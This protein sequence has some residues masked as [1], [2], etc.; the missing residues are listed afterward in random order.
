[1]LDLRVTICGLEFRNPVLPAAGPNVRDGRHLVEAA[2]GGAGALVCKT[3]SVTAAAVPMPHMAEIRGGMLNTELWSELPPE[4]WLATEYPLARAAADAAGIPLIMSLGYSA[5]E[6]AQLAPLVAPFADAVELS[7]HYLGEDATPMVRAIAAAKAALNVPVF[8]KLSPLGREM[9][10]AARAAQAA[11]ADAIV[12]TNSLGPAFG[13]DIETGYPLLG[14][15]N[16]YGWLSGPAL[17]PLALRCVYDLAQTVDLPVLGVGGIN[18]GEDVVEY[19]MAGASAVQVCTAAVLRGPS[20]YGKIAAQ[21]GDWL[22]AHGH[23]SPAAIRG[24]VL[25]RG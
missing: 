14:G 7:T 18:R 25:Q 20:V 16:S 19:L 10:A 5:E 9:R 23:S 11:G 21:L 22:E 24:A 13:L 4:Q 12:A 6:I 1:M 8:V 3:V 15:S 17:K 2:H